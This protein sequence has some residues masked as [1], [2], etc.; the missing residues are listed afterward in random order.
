M[1]VHVWET[2]KE[3]AEIYMYFFDKRKNKQTAVKKIQFT[4]SQ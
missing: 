1:D 2:F 3:F 4:N